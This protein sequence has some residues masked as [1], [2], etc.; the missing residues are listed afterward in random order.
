MPAFRSGGSA[1]SGTNSQIYRFVPEFRPQHAVRRSSTGAVSLSFIAPQRFAD[2][3]S[4][5]AVMSASTCS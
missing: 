3:R 5:A 1:N 2:L 4:I